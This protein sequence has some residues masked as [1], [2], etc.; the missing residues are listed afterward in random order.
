MSRV[1]CPKRIIKNHGRDPDIVIYPSQQQLDKDDNYDQLLAI[2][3][4]VYIEIGP[5]GKLIIYNRY[6]RGWLICSDPSWPL[7]ELERRN[8]L[9]L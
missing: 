9:P 7:E 3:Y 1:I 5:N 6:E 4:W 2:E 8:L